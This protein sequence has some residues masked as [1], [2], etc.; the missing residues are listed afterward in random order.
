MANIMASKFKEKLIKQ[1]QL[2][3]QKTDSLGREL[4]HQRYN[5]NSA[6]IT[7][8]V[9]ESWQNTSW[10]I[11]GKYKNQKLKNLPLNYLGWVIDNFQEDSVGYKLAKQELECRYHNMA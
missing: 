5:Q 8:Q 6:Q 7:K 4:T 3:W 9:V 1:S 10:P 2:E 11:T